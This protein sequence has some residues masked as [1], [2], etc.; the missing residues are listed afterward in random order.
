[1]SDF[2]SS[3]NYLF[4]IIKNK[5]KLF[6]IVGVVAVIVSV[7]ISSPSIIAP[8]Y[9]S[10]AVV[11]PSNL[12]EYSSE[13]PIEQMIQWFESVEIKNNVIKENRLAD[14][15]EIDPTDKLYHYY[16]FTVYDENISISETRYESAEIV[17]LDEDPEIALQIVNSIINNFNTVVREVRLK[18]VNENYKIIKYKYDLITQQLDSLGVNKKELLM[19][20]SSI[21]RNDRVTNL[22][23]EYVKTNANLNDI[24]T[25]MNN[26]KTFTN[27]VVEP[28]VSHKKVYPVR[29][30]IVVIS[31][32]VSILLTFMTLLFANKIKE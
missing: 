21:T 26:N 11:Y 9:K 27:V 17:V 14:H 3:N 1:M 29:W 20:E 6:V 19:T 15:Y 13:S 16:M 10:S 32:V 8:K 28:Y 25:L 12:G 7:I 22:L 4:E 31:F 5:I 24:K 30:L 23:K 18:R 2:N